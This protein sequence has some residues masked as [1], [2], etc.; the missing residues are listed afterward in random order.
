MFCVYLVHLLVFLRYVRLLYSRK[1]KAKW[2]PLTLALYNSV[3]NEGRAAIQWKIF[4]LKYRNLMKKIPRKYTPVLFAFCMAIA[5]GLVMSFFMT[6][7]NL[8]FTATF[9]IA[10]MRAF[11]VGCVIGVPVGLLVSIPVQKLISKITA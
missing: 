2:R 8:G 7:V 10:W 11:G 6:A 3:R 9:V 5:M 4:Q 1:Q